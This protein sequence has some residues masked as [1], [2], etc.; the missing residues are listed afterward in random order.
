MLVFLMLFHMY[1]HVYGTKIEHNL[2]KCEVGIKTKVNIIN[3]G[4]REREVHFPSGPCVVLQ[5]LACLPEYVFSTC[6]VTG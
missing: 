6:M 3:C 5:I 1:G 2:S 4:I